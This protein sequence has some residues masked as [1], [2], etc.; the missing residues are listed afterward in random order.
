VGD[1]DTGRRA[2]LY[3]L[4]AT[5]KKQ[6]TAEE[7]RWQAVMSAVKSCS[8]DGQS[9]SVWSRIA[10]LFRGDRLNREIDEELE[11]HIA[12]AVQHGRD[13]AQARRAFGSA[14]LR[15]DESHDVRVVG[16]LDSLRADVI[17]GWRQLRKNKV[18]SAAAIL[19][20]TLAIGA[21]TSAFRL[22]DALLLRPLPIV[23]PHR[24]YAMFTSGI[25]PNGGFRSTDFNEYPQFSLTRTAVKHQAE[26]V[27][28][29]WVDRIDLTYGA[30]SIRM[31]R[32]T[33]GS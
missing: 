16:W 6:L 7:S 22:I 26:L 13:P 20:L 33:G 31:A 2:R 28:V 8:K 11:S 14:L 32:I 23:D 12:E 5:G 21:C 3:T 17:F 9:M 18:T 1:K 10:N 27:A 15:R 24:L 29:S 19:S 4:G 25:G 30:G